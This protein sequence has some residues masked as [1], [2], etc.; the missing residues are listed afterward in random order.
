MLGK[1]GI[2]VSTVWRHVPRLVLSFVRSSC[3]ECGD[4]GGGHRGQVE[5]R[6]QTTNHV[7]NT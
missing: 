3:Y 5:P 1:V 2:K 6:V 7:G 4:S